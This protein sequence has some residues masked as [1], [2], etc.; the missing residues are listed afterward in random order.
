MVELCHGTLTYRLN[1][2][3]AIDEL[4]I[5]RPHHH[6]YTGILNRQKKSPL[7]S[8]HYTFIFID[9]VSLSFEIDANLMRLDKANTTVS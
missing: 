3:K 6:M 5:M 2:A 9:W 4:H 1:R 8:P 7:I